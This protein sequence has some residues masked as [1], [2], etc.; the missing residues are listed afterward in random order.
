LAEGVAL[1]IMPAASKQRFDAPRG[2]NW[3]ALIGDDLLFAEGPPAFHLKSLRKLLEKA[4]AAYIL[5]GPGRTWGLRRSGGY[6]RSAANVL[7]V[8]TQR[9]EQSPGYSS[10]Q[11]TKAAITLVNQHR[12]E[13]SMTGA[14][15]P[16]KPEVAPKRWRI[17]GNARRV[18]EAG[19]GQC[20]AFPRNTRAN[21]RVFFRPVSR[22]QHR[23]PQPGWLS[24]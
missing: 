14:A 21:P 4:S 23:P 20:D 17:C 5:S 6:R 12:E 13:S 8:E 3:I 18:S 22:L 7:I 24:K 11:A 15:T 10:R 16:P 19:A 1:L 9:A 2:R